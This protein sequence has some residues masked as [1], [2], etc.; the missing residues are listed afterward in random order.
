MMLNGAIECI[1]KKWNKDVKTV[2]INQCTVPLNDD[3]GR[4]DK[5]GRG[6]GRE[7]GVE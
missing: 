1:R 6:R 7:G 4:E 5:T 3:E 2:T